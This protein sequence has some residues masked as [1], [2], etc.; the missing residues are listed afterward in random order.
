M[1]NVPLPPYEEK[2]AE[3]VAFVDLLV[4][5]IPGMSIRKIEQ[6]AGVFGQFISRLRSG[7]GA[8]YENVQKLDAYLCA[9][10]RQLAALGA[11]ISMNP[12][13]ASSAARQ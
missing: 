10:R 11:A 5:A 12:E 6:E 7:D 13:S 2:R 3:I 4:D 8:T 9:K 1:V